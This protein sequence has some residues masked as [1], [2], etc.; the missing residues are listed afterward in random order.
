[1]GAAAPVSH[2]QWLTQTVSLKPGWNAVFLHVDASHD[3][4]DALVG[5]ACANPRQE[6]WRWT[7][8]SLAQFTASPS[9]PSPSVEWL[10]W[11]RTN[12][13]NA[14]LMRLVGDSAYR[15]RVESNITSYNWS[16]K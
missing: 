5:N 6:V 16:I 15:V 8:A 1:M 12:A 14:S 10:S 7:P 11:N 2:A 4:L 9:Q 13:A 3:T